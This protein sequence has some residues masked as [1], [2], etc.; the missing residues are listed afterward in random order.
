LR[1][2]DIKQLRLPDGWQEKAE[3][4]FEELCALDRAERDRR[5]QTKA[6]VWQELKAPLRALSHQKCWYCESVRHR[7]D[8]AVDHFRPKGRVAECPDHGGYWW[9]A[10][11]W[12]NYRF[13]CTWCNSR[14]RDAE[15]GDSGGK[16]DH[17]PLLDEPKRVRDRNKSLTQ[18]EPCLIDPI[19]DSDPL[20]LWFQDDGQ[21]VQRYP[22]QERLNRRASE[23]IRLYFLNYHETVER[24]KGLF[25]EIRELVNEGKAYFD[26]WVEGDN[27]AHLA[28]DQTIIR[29]RKLIDEH[30]EFSAAAR[31]YLR[32]LR[33]NRHAWIEDLVV[34]R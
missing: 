21:V 29:L 24:R 4:A 15:T 9:L 1:F 13:S 31:A 34:Q 25:N 17:F 7:S 26:R 19:V 27:T 5:L 16:Q 22:N 2:I 32:G 3:R 33:D 20:L 8:D 10:F 18:E 14:R 6:D 23:S 11:D 30:S 12:H 28:F